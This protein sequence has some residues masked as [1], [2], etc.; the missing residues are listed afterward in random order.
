MPPYH[1][2]LVPWLPYLVV[3][4]FAGTSCHDCS[5]WHDGHEDAAGDELGFG[6]LTLPLQYVRRTTPSTGM[7]T[8]WLWSPSL[9]LS[10]AYTSTFPATASTCKPRH[11]I[12]AHKSCYNAI[13]PQHHLNT[14]H[15]SRHNSSNGGNDAPTPTATA[16]VRDRD[17]AQAPNIKSLRLHHSTRAPAIPQIPATSATPSQCVY[18]GLGFGS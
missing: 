10:Q 7:A 8:I 5:H 12:M 16:A 11:A 13:P 1:C 9:I 4:P 3:T 18:T 15:K 17:N 6:P 14:A 2:C